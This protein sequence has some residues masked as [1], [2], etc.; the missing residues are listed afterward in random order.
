MAQCKRPLAPW[1]IY[2]FNLTM[3]MSLLHRITGVGLS[4]VVWLCV[5]MWSEALPHSWMLLISRWQYVLVWF[6]VWG[7]CY[8]MLSGIRHLV[9]D[10]GLFMDSKTLVW[11]GLLVWL[12]SFLAAW[13]V[14]QYGVRL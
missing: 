12:G 13:G 4:L 11:S 3:T 1:A 14:V 2:R 9:W 8:H 7:V 5:L 10:K 6:V